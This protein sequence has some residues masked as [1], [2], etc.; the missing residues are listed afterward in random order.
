MLLKYQ[1]PGEVDITNLHR[2]KWLSETGNIIIFHI[3]WIK[4]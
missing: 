2:S 1:A 3:L 4:K